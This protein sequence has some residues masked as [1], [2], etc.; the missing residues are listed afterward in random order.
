MGRPPLDF[1]V[2]SQS[3]GPHPHVIIAPA[4]HPLASRRRI[5]KTDLAGHTFLV[6]EEGSGTRSLFESFF[7][8]IARGPKVDTEIGSNETI[9]QAVIAG[10]GLSLISAHTI[11]AEVSSGRLVVL[12]VEGLP[13]VREWFTVHRTDRPL[14]TAA[15]ALWAFLVKEGNSFLP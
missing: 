9:K 14:Q 13:I 6:R 3:I 12:D 2:E 11:A 8:G 10:L 1:A 15:Q 7:G 5:A 4:D